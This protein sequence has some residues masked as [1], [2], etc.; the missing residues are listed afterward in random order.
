MAMLV[1]APPNLIVSS[2]EFQEAWIWFLDHISANQTLVEKHGY[3]LDHKHWQ[4]P[5]CVKCIDEC[6]NVDTYLARLYLISQL[7]PV[8]DYLSNLKSHTITFNL[9]YSSNQ[10]DEDVARVIRAQETPNHLNAFRNSLSEHLAYWAILASV[11]KVT[12]YQDFS[13]AKP[14][15]QPE[16]KGPDGLVCVVYGN[17]SIIKIISVKNSINSPQG[18]ISSAL[19]EFFAFQNYNRGFQRLD[20]KLNTLQQELHQDANNQIRWI[21]L[22]HQSQFNASA[23]AD[24]QYATDNLFIG[25]D[26]ISDQPTRR[27]GIYV[28]SGNWMDLADNVQIKVKEILT[29][30]RISF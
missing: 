5:D 25:F 6:D 22:N 27:V 11:I 18:L 20:E 24:E 7:A 17:Y 12:G 4:Y 3:F 2:Q 16:D 23:I 14:N 28:G 9:S 26:K 8:S 21:L 13:I 10:L 1:N 29:Q 30:K 15:L 19:D